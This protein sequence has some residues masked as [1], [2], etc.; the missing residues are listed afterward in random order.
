MGGR[1]KMNHNISAYRSM[2][3]IFKTLGVPLK[4]AKL[5]IRKD[6][7]VEARQFTCYFIKV[8]RLA[9]ECQMGE[10]LN[11][12]HSTV[13]YS[14]RHIKSLSESN[15]KTKEL[16][17]KLHHQIKLGR[18]DLSFRPKLSDQYLKRTIT[19]LRQKE[20]KKRPVLKKVVI[21]QKMTPE[22]IELKS[23]AGRAPKTKRMRTST[24]PCGLT[25][26]FKVKF[27][28]DGEKKEYNYFF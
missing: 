5:E 13:N 9:T 27:V 22:G 12:D 25:N 17:N 11:I 20:V 14:T 21:K 8:N 7:V 26:E 16:L 18:P 4:F 6:K 24:N 28:I 15:P 23:K 3:I 2:I 10:M 19:P 1:Y